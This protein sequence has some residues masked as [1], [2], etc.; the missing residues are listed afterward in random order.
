[1]RKNATIGS[2]AKMSIF[3]T[4]IAG[5]ARAQLNDYPPGSMGRGMGWAMWVDSILWFLLVIL[6]LLGGVTLVRALRYLR[7]GRKRD[8]SRSPNVGILN[9]PHAKGKIRREDDPASKHDLR[10]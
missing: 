1:M 10:G 2:F 6:L 3:V 5:R 8:G 4:A 9:Q 7:D